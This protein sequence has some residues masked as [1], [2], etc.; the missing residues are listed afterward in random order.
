MDNSFHAPKMIKTID[1]TDNSENLINWHI[2]LSFNKLFTLRKGTLTAG[3]IQKTEGG[4]VL[5]AGHAAP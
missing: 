1:L 2:S 4:Y 3:Q 5:Y